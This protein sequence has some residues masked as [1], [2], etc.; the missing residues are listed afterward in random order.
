MVIFVCFA[1]ETCFS[2]GWT[3]NESRL[4]LSGAESPSK[5]LENF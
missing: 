1:M 4:P 3:R 5:P 2:E